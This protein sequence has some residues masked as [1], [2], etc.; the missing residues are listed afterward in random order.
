MTISTPSHRM[1]KS[2]KAASRSPKMEHFVR[3]GFK[4]SR[5][6]RRLLSEWRRL[7]LPLSKATI[8]VAVSGGADSVALLRAL[9]EL[10]KSG[11]L[12]ARLVVAHLNH[13]L[14]GPK[15][16]ADAR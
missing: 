16:D 13:K 14:R 8:V 5:F 1:T 15:S 11:K 7:G 10:V 4:L 12:G 6:S 2:R 9:D 3:P